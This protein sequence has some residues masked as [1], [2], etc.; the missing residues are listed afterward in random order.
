MDVLDTPEAGGL[1]VRGGFFRAAGFAAGTLLSLGAI[2]L[3]T[4]HLGVVEFGRFQVVVSLVAVVGVV[5]DLGMATVGIRE[6]A[7]REGP[8]RD[9]LMRSI[10]GMRLSVTVVGV[11]IATGFALVAGYRHDMVVGVVIMGVGLLALVVQTTLQIPLSAGL[12]LGAVSVLDV[13]RQAMQAALT[14][15]LV[16]AGAALLPF[17]TI[18]IPVHLALVACTAALVGR[19]ISLRP[20]FSVREWGALVRPMLVYSLAVAVGIVYVYTAQILMSLVASERETGLFSAGFRVFVILAAVPSLLASAAFPLLSRAALDDQERLA[21]VARGLFAGTVLVGGAVAV[22]CVVGADPII[23]LIAGP[24]FE[25]AAAVLR[26][27]GVALLL[28]FVIAAWGFTLLAQHRHRAMVYAN[29][30]ALVTS[31]VTVLL[32]AAGFGEL[33]AAL[34]TLLGEVVLAA[35]YLWALTRE[36]RDLRPDLRQ[37][38]RVAVALAAAG[39]VAL[40][41]LPTAV[42]V[43]LALAAYGAVA[44][45]AGAVPEDLIA[46]LP[47]QLRHRLRRP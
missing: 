47:A 28:T 38:A 9:R 39:G 3:L 10:L 15:L 23:A 1:V 18:T 13:A 21:R 14:A 5:T 26:I 11:A 7:Q 44:Y 20:S 31:S 4:R 41:S 22:A 29:L 17:F 12:R 32:L 6:Y 33:G 40:L 2:V 27:Q 16:F 34:G 25:P 45:F 8:D 37:V 19:T 36:R 42:S 24:G 43:A 35:A 30:A 46:Q